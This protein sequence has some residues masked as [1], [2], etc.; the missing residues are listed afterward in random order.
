MQN[1]S[2][3]VPFYDIQNSFITDDI[4]YITAVYKNDA[5]DSILYVNGNKIKESSKS[6]GWST[7]EKGTYIGRRNNG[8]YFDG[9][10]Y[11]IKIYKKALSEDEIIKE[12]QKDK[13]YYEKNN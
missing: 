5:S 11:K 7:N 12:Y 10:L 2:D 6:D 1:D 4:N 3:S 8:S 9:T 13:E